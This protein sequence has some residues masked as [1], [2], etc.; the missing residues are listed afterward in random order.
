MLSEQGEGRDNGHSFG[1]RGLEQTVW[2]KEMAG[3]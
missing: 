1:F 2:E 3:M